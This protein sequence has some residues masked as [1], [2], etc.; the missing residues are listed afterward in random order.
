MEVS[1]CQ[2]PDEGSK[3]ELAHRYVAGEDLAE[4][5]FELSLN[6]SNE[7]CRNVLLELCLCSE[8]GFYFVCYL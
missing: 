8:A 6:D 7:C 1:G 4:S 2:G 5:L 3:V